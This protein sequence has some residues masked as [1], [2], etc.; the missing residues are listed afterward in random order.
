MCSRTREEQKQPGDGTYRTLKRKEH[1]QPQGDKYLQ[2]QVPKSSQSN[3]VSLNSERE[4]GADVPGD[5]TKAQ[6]PEHDGAY[7]MPVTR[8]RWCV[9]A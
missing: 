1:T 6:G 4:V 2:K 9:M 7:F 5:I 8:L 3:P